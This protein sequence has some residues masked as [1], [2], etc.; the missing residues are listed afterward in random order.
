[1]Y[2]TVDPAVRVLNDM[3]APKVAFATVIEV[4]VSV[5]LIKRVAPL[6]VVGKEIVNVAIVPAGSRIRPG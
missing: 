5:V 1:M 6:E 2:R 4:I 3:F